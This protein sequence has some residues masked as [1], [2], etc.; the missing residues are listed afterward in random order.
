MGLADDATNQAKAGVNK[1]LSSVCKALKDKGVTS[2]A[3]WKEKG[4]SDATMN[5]VTIHKDSNNYFA[6][7]TMIII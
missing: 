4:C 7:K 3:E 1:A 6:N 2:G 5:Q